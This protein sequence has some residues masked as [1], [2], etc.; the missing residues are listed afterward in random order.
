MIHFVDYW[1][2]DLSCSLAILF[3]ISAV[4]MADIEKVFFLIKGLKIV[5]TVP[6]G[7][8]FAIN[9][10]L[11]LIKKEFPILMHILDSEVKYM[12]EK[13]SFLI[14]GLKTVNFV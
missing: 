14:I 13:I 4:L 2:F 12:H 10:M 3:K 5:N 11:S 1:G 7:L 6:L 8:I 9:L